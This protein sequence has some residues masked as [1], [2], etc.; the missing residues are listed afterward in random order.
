[1]HVL[2]GFGQLAAIIICLFAFIFIVIAVAFNLAMVLGTSWLREKANLIKMLRPTVDSVNKTTEASLQGQVS[3]EGEDGNAIAHSIA[4]VP[5]AMQSADKKV[6]EVTDK[7][8][9]GAIEFR[10]RTIQVQTVV[11]AFLF[12]KKREQLDGKSVGIDAEGLQ[13]KSPGYQEL[14]KEK[15]AGAS[16]E[17]R[18]GNGYTGQAV[19][20]S[21][22]GDDVAVR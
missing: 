2:A 14:M 18:T 6:D 11:K 8:A 21:Q 12:P 19:T 10:A 13:F 5:T 20:A 9:H 7:V 3:A 16:A 4:K 22:L 1:M 17:A 15:A